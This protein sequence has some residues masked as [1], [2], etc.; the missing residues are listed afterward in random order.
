MF[1]F[2]VLGIEFSRNK[3]FKEIND[4]DVKMSHH[5]LTRQQKRFG[6]CVRKAHFNTYHPHS[7]GNF[8]SRCLRKRK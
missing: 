4:D 7:F 2:T 8:M 1:K 5:K 3:E 6:K